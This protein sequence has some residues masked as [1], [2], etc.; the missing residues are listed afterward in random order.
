MGLVTGSLRELDARKQPMNL[1]NNNWDPFLSIQSDPLKPYMGTLLHQQFNQNALDRTKKGG[2]HALQE[3]KNKVSLSSPKHHFELGPKGVSIG[4]KGQK[5]TIKERDMLNRSW[6]TPVQLGRTVIPPTTLPLPTRAEGQH[7]H[8]GKKDYNTN[9]ERTSGL[10]GGA[11]PVYSSGLDFLPPL[12]KDASRKD[13][14][15]RHAA[16]APPAVDHREQRFEDTNEHAAAHRSSEE[17][18]EEKMDSPRRRN[19]DRRMESPR[20]EERI[21]R[22]RGDS[23]V[24]PGGSIFYPPHLMH[25]STS[26][27]YVDDMSPIPD[28]RYRSYREF[29]EQRRGRSVP[30]MKRV[31]R[32]VYRCS[33]LCCL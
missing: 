31:K 33:P 12:L 20:R 25:R 16:H 19:R 6:A 7:S 11:S 14:R 15:E 18:S 30:P 24:P 23:W 17:K 29:R 5:L 13:E 10:N 28:G 8:Q 22:I 2:G 21:R 26:R 9:H 32:R 1:W 3:S 4:N 27:R